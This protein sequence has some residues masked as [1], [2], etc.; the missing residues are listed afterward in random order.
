MGSPLCMRALVLKDRLAIGHPNR[1][2]WILLL[3]DVP[4]VTEK[5]RWSGSVSA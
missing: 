1:Q 3:Q 5:P 2:G 4:R